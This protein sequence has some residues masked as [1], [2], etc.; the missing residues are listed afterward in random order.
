MN[1]YLRTVMVGVLACL[2]IGLWMTPD[3]KADTCET[4][5]DTDVP[6][7]PAN[8]PAPIICD[9]HGSVRTQAGRAT[10][11]APALADGTNTSNSY[12]LSGNLRTS[13]SIAGMGV[14]G[15]GTANAA[16]PTFTEASAG[17]FSWDLAGNLRVTL[18]TQLAGEDLTNNLI[19]TSGGAVRQTQILGTGGVPS[20]ATDATSATSILPVG[21]K[22]FMGV[23]TCTGTCVQTQKIYGTWLNT[24][25]GTNSEL[26]CTLTLNDTTNAHASCNVTSNWSFYFVVTTLTSGTTPLAGVFAMY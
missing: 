7:F 19:R 21:T 12:D 4:R 22:T 25:S 13:T 26:L 5:I 1:R 2:S 10:G 15:L 17:Y 11:T 23:V 9:T 8:K 14:T 3:A 16:S 20:T 24:A 18:G 6:D